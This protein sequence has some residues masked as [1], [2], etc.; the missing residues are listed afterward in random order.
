MN[1]V[2]GCEFFQKSMYLILAILTR[3]PSHGSHMNLFETVL[4]FALVDLYQI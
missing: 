3:P 4:V 2:N 1:G